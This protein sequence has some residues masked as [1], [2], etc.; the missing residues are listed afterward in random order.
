MPRIDAADAQAAN[1]EGQ[2][3][4]MISGSA[5]VDP[6]AEERAKQRRRRHRP[7]NQPEHA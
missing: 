4:G 3:P 7:A 6:G 2:S 1:Q 5:F